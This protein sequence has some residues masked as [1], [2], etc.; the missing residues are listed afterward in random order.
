MEIFSDGAGSG[1][2]P[3]SGATSPL[4]QEIQ[5]E[6]AKIRAA[7]N[8]GARGIVGTPVPRWPVHL[9]PVGKRFRCLVTGASTACCSVLAE[10]Q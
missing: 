10:S 1:S 5:A 9:F 8:V 4:E 7:T 2:A 3:A 6:M